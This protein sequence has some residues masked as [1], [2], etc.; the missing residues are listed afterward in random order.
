MK[1]RD[2]RREA[3]S[4]KISIGFHYTTGKNA[5]NIASSGLKSMGFRTYFGPGIYVG[6]NPEAFSGL[7]EV[8]IVVLTLNGLQAHSQSRGAS[9]D[10]DNFVGVDS[11][12]GNKLYRDDFPLETGRYSD[13]LVFR[14]HTQVLPWVR[15]DRSMS[16]RRDLMWTTQK[17]I[18]RILDSFFPGGVKIQQTP[19]YPT[20]RDSAGYHHLN[21][22]CKT[23]LLPARLDV[24]LMFEVSSRL[25]S[26]RAKQEKASLVTNETCRSQY[27]RTKWVESLY[28]STFVE[29]PEKCPICL[30]DVK[31]VA[32][33]IQKCGHRF[34]Q[35]C[36]D[37]AL[38]HAKKC[39]TCRIALGEP[40]GS[41]PVGTMKIRVKDSLHCDGF[42]C[43]ETIVITYSILDGIQSKEHENPG[44]LFT[45]TTRNAYLPYSE[46]GKALL[47]RLRYAFRRGLTFTVGTSLTTG[48]QNVV[49]WTSIHHKTSPTAGPHG[50]PDPNYFQNCNAEL[51]QL[52]VPKADEL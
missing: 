27:F 24:L 19:I 48:R 40:I 44:S 41:C 52:G 21:Q 1:R 8:G 25:N 36:I 30:D 13:E 45:G 46:E 37:Q 23:H 10:K 16:T 2:L 18:E 39:P 42:G 3:R 20:K 43:M 5:E 29:D 38:E 14:S 12:I 22:H 17:N 6:N 7:G 33:A 15:F 4:D 35:D 9:E 49:V 34:H 51:D 32:V 50:W 31:G 26:L 28:T 11:I 47:K